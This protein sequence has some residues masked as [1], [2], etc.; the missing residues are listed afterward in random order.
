MVVML[1]SAKGD[2]NRDFGFGFEAISLLDGWN[3]MDKLLNLLA[4]TILR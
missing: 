1:R 4:G 3:Q 2:L